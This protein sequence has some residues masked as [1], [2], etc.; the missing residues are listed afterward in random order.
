MGWFGGKTHYFWKHPYMKIYNSA[1]R[2]E[3]ILSWPTTAKKWVKPHATPR[4]STF[5]FFESRRAPLFGAEVKVELNLNFTK[6]IYIYT[7]KPYK[8]LHGRRVHFN[9]L[10]D[11]LG[12]FVSPVDLKKTPPFCRENPYRDSYEKRDLERTFCIQCSGFF[13]FF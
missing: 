12:R 9:H 11:P 8:T 5:F 13:P 3:K 6:Y 7:I 4:F 2:S 1:N 10:T